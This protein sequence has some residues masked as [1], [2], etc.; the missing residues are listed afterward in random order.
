MTAIKWLNDQTDA[1]NIGG[2]ITPGFW[3]DNPKNVEDDYTRGGIVFSMERKGERLKG[4]I[5]S[6]CGH[7]EHAVHVYKTFKN[8]KPNALDKRSPCLE[9]PPSAPDLRAMAATLIAIA[10]KIDE[11]NAETYSDTD[12][13]LVAAVGACRD[14]A[15][16]EDPG[17]DDLSENE[18]PPTPEAV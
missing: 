12:A 15:M 17:L 8:D 7:P 4:C 16:N 6:W 13:L 2:E 11:A 5:I 3:L 10:R 18:G 9:I 1:N 14:D